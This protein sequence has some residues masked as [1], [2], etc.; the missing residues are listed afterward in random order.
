MKEKLGIGEFAS[1]SLKYQTLWGGLIPM[2]LFAA[3]AIYLGFTGGWQAIYWLYI[4]IGYFCLMMLGVTIGYH[5]LISHRSF[6]THPIF[7]Y[8]VTI[9]GML[10]GQGSPI[11]WTVTHRCL[12]H[13]YSDTDR[14]P[15]TPLKGFFHSWFLWLW[16]IEESDMRTTKIVDLI[17]DPFIVFCHKHY[18]KLYWLMNLAIALISFEFWLWAV[19]IPSAI[20]FHSY[21]I[22]N[23]LTHYKILGYR[24]YDTRDNSTNTWWLW[25]VVLGEC[26][27]NNHHGDAKAYNFGN[28][29]WWE[30]DPSGMI[31]SLIRKRQ[32]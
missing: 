8:L 26:W 23:S 4:A 12:H 21:S 11:F 5:R 2:H 27:H 20:A 28:R 3:Y 14:D 22:T 16:K 32:T 17:R 25:P 19:V 7:S 24:N 15:H 31:I 9:F 6:E 30:L 29:R 18:M 10:A 1:R 13:P